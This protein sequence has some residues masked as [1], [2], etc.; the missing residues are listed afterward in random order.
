MTTIRQIIEIPA[1]L[2][3]NRLQL[4]VPLPE[5]YPSGNVTKKK[6]CENLG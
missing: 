1:T 6:Y 4:D 5:K 3:A 2:P